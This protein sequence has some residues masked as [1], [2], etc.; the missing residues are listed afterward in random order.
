LCPLAGA[1]VAGADPLPGRVVGAGNGREQENPRG[2]LGPK[3]WDNRCCLYRAAN[4]GAGSDVSREWHYAEAAGARKESGT[5]PTDEDRGAVEKS[6]VSQG[7]WR[8]D[9]QESREQSSDIRS[10][11][12]A[13]KWWRGAQLAL[14][15]SDPGIAIA[16]RNFLRK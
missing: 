4:D 15:R 3:E 12:V 5:N 7:S 8:G 10:Q 16:S 6:Y 14:P 11:S 1:V 9:K 13:G 2:E